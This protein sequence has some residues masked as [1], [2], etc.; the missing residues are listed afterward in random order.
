MIH[1]PSQSTPCLRHGCH[2]CCV[3]TRMTLTERDVA[4]LEAAGHRHF[5]RENARGELRILTGGGRCIFLQDG[6]CSAYDGRPDGCRTYPLVLD[7]DSGSAVLHDFCPHVEEF[8]FTAEAA[9]RL[10]RSVA[11]EEAEARERRRGR[12]AG[13][14][15]LLALAAAALA[16]AAQGPEPPVMP[17]EVWRDL[18]SLA[19]IPKG[20]RVLMQSSHCR[21]GC[22]Q[23]RHAS[24]DSRFIRFEGEEGVVFEHSG[25]G[26]IT[27]IWMTQGEGGVSHPLDPEIWIRVVVDGEIVVQLPLPD[28]FGGGVDP[29][30]PPLAVERSASAGGNLSYVPIAFRES[31]RLSLLGAEQA[32]IW[33]QVTYHDLVDSAHVTAFTGEESLAEWAALLGNAGGDPW[34]GGPSLI[35]SGELV[36]RRGNRVVAAAFEGPDVLNG[37]LLR[38]DRA[39]WADLSVRLVFDGEVTVDLP[40]TEFFAVGAATDAPTRSALIG[41]GDEGDLYSYFPMPFFDR[42]VVQLSRPPRGGRR[43]VSVEY[44]IRRLGRP[45]VPGSGL[46]R[47]Q[48]SESGRTVAGAGHPVLATKGRGRWVGLFAE[49]GSLDGGGRD[50]LEGDE[51][52]FIDGSAEPLLHGTGV[53]DFFGGGFYFRGN[54]SRSEVFRRALHGMTYNLDEPA[55]EWTT[56]M[57]RLMLT[58]A[59]NWSQEVR[60]VLESGPVNRTPM[61]AKTVAYYYQAPDPGSG[62]GEQHQAGDAQ[63]GQQREGGD[64]DGP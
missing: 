51:Q 24:G 52:V 64:T 19:V 18:A 47:A 25:P 2:A 27:R 40:L 56:G 39:A 55:G 35:T 13:P 37:L 63:Q 26:A 3:G 5:C 44:A 15:A 22:A 50:Y 41:A 17:W 53:E 20:D 8:E 23:D 49:L 48:R 16:A 21:A 54:D 43:K 28:F 46:F 9:R 60:V 33:F 30:T 29:F 57:Y 12:R 45:P 7:L 10:R 11:E 62:H 36:L 61:R 34:P 6:L 14:L 59:P 4:R 38:V 1:E 32:K 42:A 31:C 58:D